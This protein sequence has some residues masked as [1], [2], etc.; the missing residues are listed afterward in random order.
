M[1]SQKIVNE[2]RKKKLSK[3]EISE[4][5]TFVATELVKNVDQTFEKEP[6]ITIPTSIFSSKLGA[7]ESTVKF[8]RENCAMSLFEIAKILHRKKNSITSTYHASQKKSPEKIKTA[9]TKYTI[10]TSVFSNKKLT[11]LENIAVELKRKYA[12]KN[13]QIAKLLQR[14]DRTIWTVINRASKKGVKK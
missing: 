12:L 13:S 9:K 4:L 14:D 5:L 1:D 10:S 3:K 7:L 2:L 6:E 8:L 11:F